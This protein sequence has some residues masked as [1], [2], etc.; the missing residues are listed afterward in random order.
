MDEQPPGI[1]KWKNGFPKWFNKLTL[2]N[3]RLDKINIHVNI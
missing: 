3:I 1:R 2:F